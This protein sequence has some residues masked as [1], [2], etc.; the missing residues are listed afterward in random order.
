M[1]SISLGKKNPNV[2]ISAKYN[3]NG[4]PRTT[5]IAFRSRFDRFF[6]VTPGM[7][8]RAVAGGPVDGRRAPAAVDGDDLHLAAI[9]ETSLVRTLREVIGRLERG[10]QEAAAGLAEHDA[11]QEEHDQEVG[12][13]VRVRQ[14]RRRRRRQRGNIAQGQAEGPAD[15]EQ[16]DG[17]RR[18]VQA[19]LD[20]DIVLL[21]VRGRLGTGGWMPS[22]TAHAIRYAYNIIP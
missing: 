7:F 6:V 1:S 19:E 8:D 12:A 22:D 4:W 14:R 20:V 16:Q 9:A 5:C 18:R 2:S 11:V 13:A 21:R 17:G 10:V 15:T 3:L